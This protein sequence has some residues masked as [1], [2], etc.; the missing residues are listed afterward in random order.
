MSL[1]TFTSKY[2]ADG[3]LTRRKQGYSF[4]ASAGAT[5]SFEIL[6]PY[7]KCKMDAVEVINCDIGDSANFKVLDDDLGSISGVAKQV[8]NQYAIGVNLCQDFYRDESKYQADLLGGL[9]ILVEYTETKGL[10]KTIYLNLDF[11]EVI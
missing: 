6:V 11:H 4:T 9:Y 7:V 2:T 1:P 8:L 5:T 10:D 3:K